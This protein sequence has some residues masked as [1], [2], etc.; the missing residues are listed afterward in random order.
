MDIETI[1]QKLKENERI[2]QIYCHSLSSFNQHNSSNA[3]V[4][5]AAVTGGAASPDNHTLKLFAKQLAMLKRCD[6]VVH[7]ALFSNH[8]DLH[9]WLK[10]LSISPQSVTAIVTAQ[11]PLNFHDLFQA[12]SEADLAPLLE[13]HCVMPVVAEHELAAIMASFANLR[14]YI[15]HVETTRLANAAAAAAAA[16]SE[17]QAGGEQS[18]VD[19]GGSTDESIGLNRYVSNKLIIFNYLQTKMG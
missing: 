6:R 4:A 8:P 14:K 18:R 3:A 16:A 9:E 12:R 7:A 13:R 17:E 19:R 1:R 10:L 5:A 15:K 2:I 11:P